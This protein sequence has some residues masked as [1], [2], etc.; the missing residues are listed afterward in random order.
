[1]V[2]GVIVM[3]VLTGMPPQPAVVQW[4]AVPPSKIKGDTKITTRT[5]KTTKGHAS[6]YNFINIC[7]DIQM[8]LLHSD[9][10]CSAMTSVFYVVWCFFSLEL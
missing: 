7:S 5:G 8:F 10:R 4:I 2:V 3:L 9:C 6:T 1:M